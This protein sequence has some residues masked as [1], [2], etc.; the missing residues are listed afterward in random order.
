MLKKRVGAFSSGLTEFYILRW[1]P[2]AAD[3]LPSLTH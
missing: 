1:K 2:Y 3:I